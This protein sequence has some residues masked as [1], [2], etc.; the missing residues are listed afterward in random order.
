MVGAVLIAS[1]EGGVLLG[2]GWVHST[3]CGGSCGTH[4][5]WSVHSHLRGVDASCRSYDMPDP[6][7]GTLL[8]PHIFGVGPYS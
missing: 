7:A 4:N 8:V 6:A 3:W 5:P 2:E 1:H